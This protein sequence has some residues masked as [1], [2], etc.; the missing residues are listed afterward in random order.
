M[1][2]GVRDHGR[3]RE[4]ALDGLVNVRDLGGLRTADGR[5]VRPRQVIRAD[6]PKS[7][8]EA[9]RAALVELVSP[10]VVVDLRIPLELEREGYDLEGVPARIVSLPMIPQSGVTD[11]QIASGLAD[12]L[13]EDYRREIE[14]N[15]ASIV[16]V[17]RLLA[18]PANRPLVVHCTAGKDRTGIV[19]AMILSILGVPDAE[20]AADYHVTSRNIGPILERIRS[21]PVFRENGLAFAPD[22]IFA[23][24]P[25]SMLAFLERLRLD[26]G[27]AEGWALAKGLTAGEIAALRAGLLD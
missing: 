23:S 25:E 21:A 7:L 10:A 8:T 3:D 18:E 6:N 12:S 20:I 22:W 15:A 2:D 13:P 11:E 19:T 17:L 27:D 24:E 14:V 1:T 9:G 16:G 4:I 5:A 26:Y